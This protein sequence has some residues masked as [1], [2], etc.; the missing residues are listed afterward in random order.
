MSGTNLSRSTSVL[1]LSPRKLSGVLR[2]MNDEDDDDGNG[3]VLAGVELWPMPI[4][5]YRRFVRVI[6]EF[7]IEGEI[8]PVLTDVDVSQGLDE[9]DCDCC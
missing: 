1:N 2:D 5:G 4:A 9:I 3:L 7:C 8:E 6:V